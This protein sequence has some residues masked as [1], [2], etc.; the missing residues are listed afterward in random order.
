[1]IVEYHRPETLQDALALLARQEPLTVPLAGGTTLDRSS[2][3]PL[4][5]VDLQALGLDAIRQ[6]GNFLDLGATVKLQD[7][8]DQAHLPE[9]AAAG[10]A[11]ALARA[12]QHQA[13]YNLRQVATVA[14][15]LVS[16][17]GRSPF[18]T[19]LLALDA[20]LNLQPG[21]T[22][23]NLGDLLPLR[24]ALFAASNPLRSRLITQVTVL[25]NARL[26]YEYVARTPADL[27]IVCAA[28]AVWPSGRV[29]LALGG[30]GSAPS[31]AFDGSETAGIEIAAQSAYSQ[32]G[33]EWA[34]A[35]YRREIA[36]V[37]AKRC[38][39]SLS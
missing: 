15:T 24:T 35:E 26:A 28:L 18:A 33:D 39:Q 2:S 19:A 31:L 22:L 34:S 25:S 21:D 38:L 29:R 20:E 9:F 11:T 4:A 27:P 7:L 13:T 10:M 8:L 12:I 3:Q 5:V 14:G 23:V 36:G 16:A 6:R 30:Y 17:G 37:L 1:M 32:A